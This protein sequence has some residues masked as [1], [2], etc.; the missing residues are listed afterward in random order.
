MQPFTKSTG[1]ASEWFLSTIY[2]LLVGLFPT[3]GHTKKAVIPT[4]GLIIERKY[5]VSFNNLCRT[6]R[7]HDLH[8]I[9]KK[10]GITTLFQKKI[11]GDI[12]SRGQKYLAHKHTHT[13]ENTLTIPPALGSE[14]LDF[15]R[16]LL[17]G[18]MVADKKEQLRFLGF[19]SFG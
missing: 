14:A 10:T 4:L 11:T 13:K 17:R 6:Y 1:S 8:C 7:E 3:L 2:L 12:A 9:N 18:R 15:S 5:A 16:R 19:W